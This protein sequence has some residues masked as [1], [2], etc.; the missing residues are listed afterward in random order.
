MK[1]NKNIPPEPIGWPLLAFPTDGS[2]SYPSL[3]DS[4]R[5]SIRVILL[6]RPGERLMRPEFGAGLDSFLHETNT[7]MT[8]KRI[9]DKISES[10]NRWEPR[11]I[12]DRIEVW[13]DKQQADT[14]RIEII[15]R[16]KRTGQQETMAMHMTLGE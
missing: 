5:Q 6:T 9:Q 16:I 3:E 15:Y 1:Q 11:I 2:L 8:R 14:V 4:I 10:I 13:E 7:L 12:A